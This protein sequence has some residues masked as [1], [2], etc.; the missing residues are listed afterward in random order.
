MPKEVKANSSE[1]Q[2]SGFCKSL[3]FIPTLAN[4]D[5]DVL[6]AMITTFALSLSKRDFSTN[7]MLLGNEFEK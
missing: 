2:G 5:L 6:G 3:C 1:F 7:T 4:M